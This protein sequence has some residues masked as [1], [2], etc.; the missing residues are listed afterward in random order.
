MNSVRI[1]VIGFL[2]LYTTL[3]AAIIYGK[4]TPITHGPLIVIGMQYDPN[5]ECP[6]QKLDHQLRLLEIAGWDWEE[7]D[8]RGDHITED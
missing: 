6:I 2:T 1:S 4:I 7:C 8:D 3:T 5:R